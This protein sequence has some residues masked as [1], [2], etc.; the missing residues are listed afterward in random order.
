[1][2]RYG[3]TGRHVVALEPAVVMR[4]LKLDVAEVFMYLVSI[5]LPKLAILCLYGRIFTMRPYRCA[6]YTTGSLIVLTLLAGVITAIAICRPFSYLWD[7]SISDGHCG[8]VIALYRYIS[9]PNL[10]TDVCIIVLPLHGVWGLQAKIVHK[11]GIT[12]TFLT[13]CL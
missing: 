13:G 7:Q 12:V 4:W 2:V 8:N 6:I 10:F 3:G 1:M 5:T 11:I 9:I